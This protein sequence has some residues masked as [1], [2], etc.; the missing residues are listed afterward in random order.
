[1]ENIWSPK[2]RFFLSPTGQWGPEEHRTPVHYHP[3][4]QESRWVW[5]QRQEPGSSVHKDLAF[6]PH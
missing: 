6:P 1:M 5:G 2:D 4:S 3:V